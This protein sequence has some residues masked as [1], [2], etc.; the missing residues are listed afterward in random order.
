MGIYDGFDVQAM[1]NIMSEQ[2]AKINLEMTGPRNWRLYVMS[3]EHGEYE[4]EGTLFLIVMKA[5]KPYLSQAKKDRELFSMSFKQWL[6]K[7]GNN[8]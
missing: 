8:V 1:L 5:F 7:G 6:R 4:N 3:P 2:D